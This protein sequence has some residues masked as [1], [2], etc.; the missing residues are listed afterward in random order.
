MTDHGPEEQ[1]SVTD[2]IAEPGG[3][4]SG[5]H[6]DSNLTAGEGM[7]N[8]ADHFD[9]YLEKAVQA[10][11][12]AG[13][14]QLRSMNQTHTV[15]YKGE[16]DL[17]TEVDRASED[18]IV[19]ILSEAFPNHDFLLEEGEGETSTGSPFQWI[20]DP[21]DGTTNYTHGY[22]HF[23]CSIALAHEGRTVVGVVLDPCLGELFTAVRGRGCRMNGQPV[24]VTGETRLIRSL[25]GTGFPY[26]MRTASDNNLEKFNR[27]ILQAR[28]VRR[29][30]SA[31]LDLCYLAAGRFDGY[32]VLNLS[33]W[34]VAAG[35]LMIEEAGGT[36][37]DLRGGRDMSGRQGIIASNGRI[38]QA[39]TSLLH[40]A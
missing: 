10:A 8:V 38:H 19:N 23:C 7:Q 29:A 4:R 6:S 3:T 33:P 31:A 17:V 24:H 2:S 37:T 15:R 16:T 9:T 13:R 26:N 14:I 30:G 22:P 40:A 21:V 20:V 32:W 12:E 39:L 35:I 5:A 34:D 28:A 11:Q 27:V 36:V 25:L 18:A 1:V